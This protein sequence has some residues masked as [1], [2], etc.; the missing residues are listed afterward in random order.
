MINLSAKHAG[1]LSDLYRVPSITAYNRLEPRAR[2]INFGRSLRA[3]IRDALWMLTRQWQMGEFEADDTGSPIDAR[4]FAEKNHVN[5]IAYNTDSFGT[6]DPMIPMEAAVEKEIVPFT[7]SLK[8][9]VGLYFL[10]LHSS[11]LRNKYIGNYRDVFGVN[12]DAAYLEKFR[13]Q[14]DALNLFNATKDKALDGE[15]IINAIRADS[16]IADASIDAADEPPIRKASD[17]LLAWFNRQYLQPETGQASAWHGDQLD[18]QFRVSAPQSEQTSIQLNATEYYNGRLDWYSFRNILRRRGDPEESNE[19]V[20]D[21][22][23]ISFIPV[24]PSFKGIP[25]A[26][27]WEMEDRQVDFGKV[28]A[29]TTDHLLLVFTEFGLIYANDWFQIPYALPVNTI[30]TIKGFVVTDVFGDRIL[31]PAA[32]EG[33]ES[34]WERWSMFSISNDD[35]IGRYN[36]MFFLPACLT[37][38]L[39]ADPVEEVRFIRDE[40][41]NMCWGIES[42]I[43][44]QNADG[45]D[46]YLAADKTGVIPD[47][48]DPASIAKIRYLLGNTVPEN[49][50]PFI[51][52]HKPGS[53]QDIRFQRAAMPDLGSSGTPTIKAKGVL[54]TENASPYYINEEEISY[55]GTIVKRSFQRTRWLNGR[56]YCWIGRTRTTGRGQGSSNLMF[57]QIL[58]VEKGEKT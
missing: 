33:A 20:A 5:R 45:I 58:P 1:I 16:L 11:S 42:I 48:V 4:I 57:D 38:S 23:V 55:A 6:Y 27:F 54:L 44:S 37:Q 52:V 17:Q 18:Y 50:I 30:C 32:G 56:T 29:K 7:H 35:N 39:E 28:N 15:K 9:Q 22:D 41:A 40:M 49:W 13:D 53:V 26:R 12:Q 2:S 21:E 3:E 25:A 14:P 31:I 10:N 36:R 8:L 43:P 34:D 46:G 51:P 47:P 19:F 24:T